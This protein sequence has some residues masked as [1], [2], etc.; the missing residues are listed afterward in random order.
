MT[1]QTL[2]GAL[3][4]PEFRKTVNMLHR[5]ALHIEYSAAGRVDKLD[6][7]GAFLVVG[8]TLMLELGDIERLRAFIGTL[9]IELADAQPVPSPPSPPG[10]A[11]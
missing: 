5:H 4:K 10:S 9:L 11:A 8:A 2:S 6:V 7:A 3:T 1:D